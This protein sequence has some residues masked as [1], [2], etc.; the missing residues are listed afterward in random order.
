MFAV[1]CMC[2]SA[3]MGQGYF[4]LKPILYIS[5]INIGN[6]YFD[7]WWTQTVATSP[8]H[9]RSGL[10]TEKKAPH[11]ALNTPHGGSTVRKIFILST[12]E[13]IIYYNVNM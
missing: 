11:I 10:P 5:G 13:R 9:L 8:K 7:E 4:V 6:R 3:H 2:G 1:N 12:M